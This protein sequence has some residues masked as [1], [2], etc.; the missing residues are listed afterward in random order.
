MGGAAVGVSAHPKETSPGKKLSTL[1]KIL[2]TAKTLGLIM[3]SS[4]PCFRREGLGSFLLRRLPTWQLATQHLLV[5]TNDDLF[6][7][8]EQQTTHERIVARHVLEE[9][10]TYGDRFLSP[11]GAGPCSFAPPCFLRKQDWGAPSLR[12]TPDYS[13]CALRQVLA[14]FPIHPHRQVWQVFRE[15]TSG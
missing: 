5:I 15:K 4:S 12:G 14:T 1:T 9:S 3:C 8:L 10:V 7:L 13:G 6:S 2:K 11:I